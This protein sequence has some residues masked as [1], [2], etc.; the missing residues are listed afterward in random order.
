MDEWKADM[1]GAAVI[2]GAMRAIAILGL[3][4]NVNG[5]KFLIFY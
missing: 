3:P 2:V 5:K 1:A 4:I